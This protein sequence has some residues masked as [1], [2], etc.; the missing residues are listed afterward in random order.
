MIN[1]TFKFVLVTSRQILKL[2]VNFILHLWHQW[3]PHHFRNFQFPIMP[4]GPS[5]LNHWIHPHL[6]V[7][8]FSLPLI[9]LLAN[10]A[11]LWMI[12]ITAKH[13]V[14]KATLQGSLYFFWPVTVFAA[15]FQI[16]LLLEKKI[17][18][19]KISF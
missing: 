19:P 1:Y 9:I 6:P 10:L 5:R 17:I 18:F 11:H 13:T 14:C 2:C 16:K 4:L 8:S 15:S 7:Y 3:L 12:F